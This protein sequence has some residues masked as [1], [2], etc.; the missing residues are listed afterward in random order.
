MLGIPPSLM[1]SVA[2]DSGQI[3]ELTEW[4]IDQAI[5]AAKEL[6]IP[7]AVNLSPAYFKRADFADR[8]IERLVTSDVDPSRLIVE[9]TEGVLISDMK[10]ARESIELLRGIGVKVYLDDFGTGYSSLS[11]LQNFELDGMKL[12]RSFIQDLGRSEKVARIVRAMIDFAHSLDMKT[13]VEGVE[14][15]WQARMVQLQGCDFLQGYQLGVPMPVD[16]LHA[17]LNADTVTGQ[18]QAG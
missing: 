10:R 7:V 8:L 6:C 17:I 18:A 1:V 16:D 15:E 5:G 13:V 3:V 11:Y 12:D 4:T 9:V 2:E 14:S